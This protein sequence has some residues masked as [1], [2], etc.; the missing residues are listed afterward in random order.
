[1]IEV[2]DEDSK[3]ID[4]VVS[5][6]HDITEQTNLLAL[7]AA[8]EAAR[9]GEYGRGFAVVADEVRTLAKRTQ[10]STEEIKGIIEK[11]QHQ[12]RL[13]VEVMEKSRLTADNSMSIT[14]KAGESLIQIDDAVQITTDMVQ[15]I[16]QSANEQTQMASSMASSVTSINASAE[17]TVDESR[18]IETSS[19]ELAEQSMR[20]SG[21]ASQF[22]EAGNSK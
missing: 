18:K 21:L 7:N 5:V 3:T 1:V 17:V 2:L 8:I 19:L 6:I 16:V 12:I 13:A 4:G 9:A 15:H 14:A 20:L 11:L 22:K 10:S